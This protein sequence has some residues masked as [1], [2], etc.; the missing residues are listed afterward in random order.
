MGHH[1]CVALTYSIRAVA[2]E[3]GLSAHTIRAWERRYGVLEPERTGTNRRVYDEA[4]VERLRRL[5]RAVAA[6]HSIGMIAGLSDEELGRLAGRSE[7]RAESG[8]GDHREVCRR[9]AMALDGRALESALSR[10]SSLLGVDGF[11]ADVAIPLL[12]ELGDGWHAGRVSVAQEHLGSTLLRAQLERLRRSMPTGTDA[13][14]LLVTTP[15]GQVHELGAHI[16]S[17]IA[18]RAGWSVL[19]LGP[20]LPAADI[21]AAS[22]KSGARAVALSVVYPEGDPLL[23]EEFRRLRVELGADMPVLVG[24]RGAPSYAPVLDEIGAVILA[25]DAAFESQLRRAVR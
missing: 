15:A 8:D 16:A 20:N 18:A 10:A 14:R 7:A 3:T 17:L 5:Q 2:E 9:A 24:G 4:D 22:R 25:D 11:L 13:P 1:A 19:Y 6:G 23:I 12:K 21:A